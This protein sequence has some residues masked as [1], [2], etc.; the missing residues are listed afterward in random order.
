[1]FP[2][3]GLQCPIQWN[4]GTAGNAMMTQNNALV[5]Q[6]DSTI[7][8]SY[9]GCDIN[10]LPIGP[11]A[12]VTVE[13]GD[14]IVAN[15]AWTQVQLYSATDQWQIKAGGDH[16]LHYQNAAS[17]DLGPSV[18]YLATYR[19]WRFRLAAATLYAEYFDGA[20]WHVVGT[21][22]VVALGAQIAVEVNAGINNAGPYTGTGTFQT[23]VV[24]P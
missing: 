6:P 10:N 13:V 2:P 14:I 9:G 11:S 23:V 3:S 1:M 18:P 21:P 4:V 22:Q 20:A 15:N 19:W 16:Q 7:A 17:Q 8:G 24:C 12:I 5:I